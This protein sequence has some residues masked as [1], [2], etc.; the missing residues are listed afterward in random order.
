MKERK[1]MKKKKVNLDE[2]HKQIRGT[3][4]GVCPVTKVV[5]SKKNSPRRK[6]NTKQKKE[7]GWLDE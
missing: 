1:K 5:E 6:N 2:L 4:N 7:N 3:W